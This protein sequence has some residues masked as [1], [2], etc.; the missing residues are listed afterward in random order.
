[1]PNRQKQKMLD[2]AKVTIEYYKE[3]RGK[4]LLTK[5]TEELK[6]SL[7]V[8]AEDLFEFVLSKETTEKIF[9]H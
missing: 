6:T 8:F 4:V 9:R 7:L 5:A 1:M 3:Q 2:Y